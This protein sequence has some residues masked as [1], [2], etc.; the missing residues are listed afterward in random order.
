MDYTKPQKLKKEEYGKAKRREGSDHV[1]SFLFLLSY[2][3]ERPWGPIQSPNKGR[4]K[5]AKRLRA[6]N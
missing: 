5:K 4:K 6:I 2:A 1:Y 3:G